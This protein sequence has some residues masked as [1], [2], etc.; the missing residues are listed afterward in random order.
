VLVVTA[1]QRDGKRVTVERG[2]IEIVARDVL[3]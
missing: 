1:V 3:K 2:D